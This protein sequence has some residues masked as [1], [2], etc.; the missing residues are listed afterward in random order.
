MPPGKLVAFASGFLVFALTA[1]RAQVAVQRAVGADRVEPAPLLADGFDFPVGF[2]DAAG[3]YKARGFS[4]G[5]H[6]GEDWDGVGGG[7]SD[8]N[9][10]VQSIGDGVV[11]YARD[12]H[13]GWGNVVIVR[14]CFREGGEL[15]T[16]DAFFAHLNAIRV[17]CGDRVTRG[18]EIGTIGTAHGLYPAHLHFE[19]RKKLD[20]GTNRASSPCDFSCYYDPTK[21]LNAHRPVSPASTSAAALFACDR[22]LR[23]AVVAPLAMRRKTS[24]T[25]LP[26][27][28]GARPAFD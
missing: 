13:A 25:P 10:A 8:F 22:T 27:E 3:Y 14:H 11:V 12:A 6:P 15:Q 20:I 2:G 23:A 16:V 28:A 19:I 5:K 4:L 9:D 18:E 21:F 26:A 7:D 1:V 17:R 24:R